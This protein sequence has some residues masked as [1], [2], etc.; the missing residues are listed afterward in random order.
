[1]AEKKQLESLRRCIVETHTTFYSTLSDTVEND[2]E[3]L[4]EELFSRQIIGKAVKKSMKYSKVMDEFWAGLSWKN[5]VKDMESHC[6]NFLDSLS[7][8]GPNGRGA[9][10]EICKAWQRQV[11]TKLG[12]P[13]LSEYAIKGQL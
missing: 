7:A 5:T 8:I 10:D 13:F 11:Q 2:M 9:A 3:K 12:I 6:E 1:M 4:T